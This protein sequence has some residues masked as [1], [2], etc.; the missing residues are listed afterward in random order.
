MGDP[1]LRGLEFI[2]TDQKAAALAGKIPGSAEIAAARATV[3]AASSMIGQR[4]SFAIETTLSGN[5][6]LRMMADARVVGYTVDL[7]FLCLDDPDMNVLRVATRVAKGGHNVPEVD[8]RRRYE[9]SLGNLARAL[10][11]ADR[12]RLVDN[13]ETGAARLIAIFKLGALTWRGEQSPDWAARF[14]I[15]PDGAA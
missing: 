13:S 2:N 9:R 14:L 5:F 10:P 8:I 12:A 6:Q 7:T 4:K 11:L 3:D 15:N 1:D